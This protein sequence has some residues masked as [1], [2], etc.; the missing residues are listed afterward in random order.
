MILILLRGTKRAQKNVS[1]EIF[2]MIKSTTAVKK[3]YK[4]LTNS[5]IL[6]LELG[7]CPVVISEDFQLATDYIRENEF[8][9][10]KK[11]SM[12]LLELVEAVDKVNKNLLN[13]F[14]AHGLAVSV[15]SKY[16]DTPADICI[17]KSNGQYY[18]YNER[19][20]NDTGIY[21]DFE[22]IKEISRS[23]RNGCYCSIK[24][25]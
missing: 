22:D 23:G 9:L 4:S 3:F 11:W 6:S 19:T 10:V 5:Q 24:L 18:L 2:K 21:F 8:S 15:T 7:A 13:D 16:I 12:A 25:K 14:V 20:G 1:K 17:R